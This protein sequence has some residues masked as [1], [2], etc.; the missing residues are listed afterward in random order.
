MHKATARRFSGV[1][2]NPLAGRAAWTNSPDAGY[3]TTLVTL[4]TSAAGQSVRLR[5]RLG[6]DSSALAAGT[7]VWRIGTLQ[8]VVVSRV[9]TALTPTSTVVSAVNP[10]HRGQ[11][12]TVTATVSSGSGVPTGSV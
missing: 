10:V 12:R 8:R 2:G 7:N 1:D 11:Q 4:P 9:C 5:F 3:I 6:S